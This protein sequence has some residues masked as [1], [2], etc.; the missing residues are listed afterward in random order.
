M[1]VGT[2]FASGGMKTIAPVLESRMTFCPTRY[3]VSLAR[4]PRSMRA[5]RRWIRS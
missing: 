5:W 1:R 3:V 4:P 2:S